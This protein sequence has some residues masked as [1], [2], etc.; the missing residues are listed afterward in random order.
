[1][2]KYFVRLTEVDLCLG[3]SSVFCK[4]LAR[5]LTD[6]DSFFLECF[7]FLLA[8]PFIF[9]QPVLDLSAGPSPD[10]RHVLWRSGSRAE[11][12]A[13]K[14][15]RSMSGAEFRFQSLLVFKSE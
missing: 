14:L 12:K 15:F 5:W 9:P 11:F 8:F 6:V 2:V 3:H 7:V 13:G 4:G 1:M 10:V